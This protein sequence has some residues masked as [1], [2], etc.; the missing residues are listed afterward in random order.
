M[1]NQEQSFIEGF[2]KRAEECGVEYSEA[3][4]LFKQAAMTM[5]PTVTPPPA[6]PA[7]PTVAPITPGLHL[8][9]TNTAQPAPDS[10]QLLFEPSSVAS[11]PKRSIDSYP[12]VP[13]TQE[14]PQANNQTFKPSQPY[15]STGYSGISWPKAT[16]QYPQQTQAQPPAPAQQPAY[17][18]GTLASAVPPSEQL[19]FEN[20]SAMSAPKRSINSYPPLRQAPQPT[21]SPDAELLNAPPSVGGAPIY[22]QS[23]GPSSAELRRIMGSYNPNSRLDKAKADAIA[24]M[25]RPGMKAQEIYNNPA[26]QAAMRRR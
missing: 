16:A 23:T 12:A 15:V 11:A 7:A 17:Q 20:S 13:P 4:S 2:I 10:N 18:P 14:A 22:Q 26:Y 21:V 25:Y 3:I 19:M 5:A 6:P 9:N 24:Q 8:A 1:T